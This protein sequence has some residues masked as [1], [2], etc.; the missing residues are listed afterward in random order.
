M[1]YLE[2]VSMNEDTSTVQDYRVQDQHAREYLKRSDGVKLKSSTVRTY[3]GNLRQYE[4]FLQD[5]D[6]SLLDAEFGDLLDFIA[7]CVRSGNRQGTIEAKVSTIGEL[8]RYIRLYTDDRDTLNFDP[9][10]ISTIDLSKYNTPEPIEREALT[11]AE[12]RQLFDAFD[13]YRNRLM[14][15]VGVET[16]LRNS[17]IRGIRLEDLSLDVGEIHVHDPKNSKPYDVP[18]TD[19]LAFEIDYWIRHHRTGFVANTTCEYLFPSQDGSQLKTNS[20]LNRLVKEAA[21]RAGIQDTIGTSQVSSHYG[22][23]L[24]SRKS[25]REWHRVTVHTLRHSCITLMKEDGVDLTYRQ[26]VANHS[27]P[28]T[29]QAYTHSSNEVFEKIRGGFNP[30]R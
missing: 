21:Q 19:D 28:D 13:S 5:R 14:A 26:M 18:I 10:R 8:Y 25:Q 3:D 20:S 24:S 29:T 30:P 27:S 23:D 17:D 16:G 12:I 2:V 4:A 15:V 1:N 11:R 6:K 7:H 22:D 9:L